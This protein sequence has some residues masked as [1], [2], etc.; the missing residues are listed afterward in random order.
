MV[1]PQSVKELTEHGAK[2]FLNADGTAGVA[3]ESDGNIVGVFKNPSNRT[4]KA[5]FD[6]LLNAIANGG[7]HLDCYVLQPEVS[8]TNLGGIYA[9]LG[10][11]PVAYLR[12]N[13]EYADPSWDYD[14]FGEPD[15]V[16]W[17]HNGDSVETVAERINTYPDY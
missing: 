4:R 11:E 17:V 8:P 12:F 7:D 2:T 5:A 16:M 10:F 14:S 3:V 9:Q 6:L 13:R 1:D 15:V